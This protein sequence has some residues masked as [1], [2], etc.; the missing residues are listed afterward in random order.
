[1]SQDQHV[2]DVILTIAKNQLTDLTTL[3]SQNSDSLD[4]HEVSV[5]SLEAMLEDAY[6]AGRR[7]GIEETA[8]LAAKRILQILEE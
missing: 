8:K 6:N 7:A 1:M 3:Q 4:F 5:W 2:A